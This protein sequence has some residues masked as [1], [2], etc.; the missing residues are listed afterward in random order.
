[1]KMEVVQKLLDNL[2]ESISFNEGEEPDFNNL[3]KLFLDGAKVM[4]YQDDKFTK[5][6]VKDINEHVKEM[7]DVFNKYPEIKNKGFLEYEIENEIVFYGPIA[8]VKSN[9]FKKY[10]NGKETI[11]QIGTNCM[12]IVNCNGRY[13]I[14]SIGWYEE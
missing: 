13:K 7:Y 11:Q 14:M 1:M 2:Y 12:Q 9:Y 4:E 5:Y 10:F 3:S 8:F 6:K